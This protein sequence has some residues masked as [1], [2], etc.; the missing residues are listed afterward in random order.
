MA[1]LEAGKI[2]VRQVSMGQR[3]T[4]FFKK[5]SWGYVF[6]LPSMLTFAIFTLFP[7]FWSFII[8]FQDF[9]P[10]GGTTWNGF[11]NYV[12]AFTTQNYVF[13]TALKNTA[14]Y[15]ILTVTANILIALILASLIQPLNK[16]A[17]TFFR[18]AYYLPA[19]TSAVIIAVIWRWMFNTQWGFLN[20][21]LSL[22]GADAVRWLS[23]PDIALNS[24]VLST[25]FTAP[26]TGV[27]LFSAAMGSVPKD[28]YEAAELEGAGPVRKWWSITLPLIRPTTL[29]VV[30]L[31][32]IA[33]FEVF[34]KVYVMVPS[35]VGDSTQTIVT[36]IYQMLYSNLNYGV[37][38]AQAI[39]LFLI[40]AT[41]SVFQFKFLR[42][43]VEY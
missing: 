24:I 22:F 10:R 13:V 20:Y 37:A 5:N 43:D 28:L 12:K 34:E 29:Y 1:Q 35:G 4:L 26:A 17:Q 33:S 15:A 14:Y 21:L 25:V 2:P 36:Q 16:Y 7:V 42:S 38:S 3:L 8:S 9:K 23:D 19:V 6:V 31:Y 40:I 32:T 30:V 41:I 39:V 27:V 18:A 11:D